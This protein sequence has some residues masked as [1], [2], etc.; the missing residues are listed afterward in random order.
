MKTTGTKT[1]TVPWQKLTVLVV[2]DSQTSRQM[3][4]NMLLHM[5]V[6][7]IFEARNAEQAMEARTAY[8]QLAD[9]VICDW[10]MPPGGTGIDVLKHVRT[11]SPALPFL[12]VTS[13]SDPESVQQA[14]TAGVDAYI[15][16]PFSLAQLQT[17]IEA[18]LALKHKA[19]I[20]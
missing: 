1:D 16:K 11:F 4:R 12:I 19:N 9:L 7:H 13:R 15:C 3:I 20:R 2:D 10:N 18:V 6:K 14:R 8:L 17:K 5:G